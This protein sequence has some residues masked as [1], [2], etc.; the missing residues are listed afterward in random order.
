VSDLEIPGAE[1][2]IKLIR[3]RYFMDRLE[4]EFAE[5]AALFK[6]S[7]YWDYEGFNTAADWMRFNCH[8]TSTAAAD[9]INVGEHLADMKESRAAMDEG[10]IGFAHVTVMAR[11]A[12]AVGKAFDETQLLPLAKENSPGKFHYKCLHYRHSIDAKAY[13]DKQAEESEGRRLRLSTAE[14]GSLLISGALDPIGG[15]VVRSAL[16]P[17][18]RP[19]GEHDYRHIE[20]RYADA[21]VELASH[22]GNQKV[23]LQVTTSLE[24][25][26]GLAGAPAAEME[27]SL[28]ISSK[29]VERFACDCSVTRVLL[30]QK[31]VVIDVGRAERTIKGPKRRALNAR[32]GH[33]RWLGCE[34]PAS[35]CD[36]HH[37]VHWIHGGGSDLDKMILLCARHHWKVHEGG[38]QLVKTDD[39]RILPV[40]PTPT[41]GWPRGPD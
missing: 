39:G 10:E 4:V 40:A 14:D 24:T 17:L 9:R 12:D 23:Q 30:N 34:R 1:E 2:S 16:E 8:M 27:F 25:L 32:D 6:Q 19:S 31:S 22:G 11:T 21:L 15:A 36:G 33:C 26:K 38:W 20:Q 7:K 37:F 13:A 18:A 41:F 29:T 3:L 28:P 35:R 5:M